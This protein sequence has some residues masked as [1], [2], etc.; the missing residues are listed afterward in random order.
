[1]LHKVEP[2]LVAHG[3]EYSVSGPTLEQYIQVV[4]LL[5]TDKHLEELLKNI[6]VPE[7]A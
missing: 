7:V 2:I 3:Q 6:F 4:N 1:M 5:G